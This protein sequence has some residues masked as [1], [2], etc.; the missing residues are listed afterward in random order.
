[1]NALTQRRILYIQ[2]TNPAAY[3]PLEHSSRILA[4]R[5]WRATFLGT[6]ASGTDSLSFEN[7]PNITVRRIRFV[8]SGLLQKLQYFRYLLWVLSYTLTWRPSI[9]YASD[10][11][12]TPIAL[13][14]SFIPGSRLVYHEHDS[15]SDLTATSHFM[16]VVMKSRSWLAR[17]AL[18]NIL[19]NEERVRFF[20]E[21]TS[22]SRPTI[23]VWNCP[24]FKDAE[25][26]QNK[27]NGIRLFYGGSIVPARL[28]KTLIEA[29]VYLPA[30]VELYVA[31]Y[32]TIGSHGYSAELMNFARTLGVQN[33]IRW[34]GVL[35]RRD[36]FVECRKAH[37]GVAL[38]PLDSSDLNER[39][40][41]GASNKPFDYLACG[42]A[43]LVSDLQSWRDFYIVNGFGV[44]CNP[45]D[46]GSIVNAVGALIG[47][48]AKLPAL[49]RLGPE[50]IR[51]EWN[52]EQQFQRVIDIIEPKSSN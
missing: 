37:V 30:D 4:N 8:K 10:P 23:C 26:D 35:Q 34:L 1:M 18:V 43:L 22:T 41:P 45:A 7:H 47:E 50:K 48:P 5:G 27:P 32:E 16:R 33:R 17:R 15:P 52:Y 19:P 20:V 49:A 3:P 24:S 28:P 14:L 46:V 25:T 44:A 2:Y 9:I 11:L 38:M 39:T 36:L 40:M 12:S 13:L 6:G 31:G 42:L 21:R 51:S 29:L